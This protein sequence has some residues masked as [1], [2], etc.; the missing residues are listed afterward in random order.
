[1]DVIAPQH[2]LVVQVVLSGR[3]WEFDINQLQVSR[4]AWLQPA[5]PLQ[6]NGTRTTLGGQV[7]DQV[8]RHH[9][10]IQL[11]RLMDEKCP[12]HHLE[13][14]VDVAIRTQ[15]NGHAGRHQLRRW[16]NTASHFAIA[17]RHVSHSDVTLVNNSSLRFRKLYT[18]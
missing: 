12:A 16:C 1:M 7:P 4:P 8:S 11:V 13:E 5:H 9:L 6:A 15:A 10:G 18:L 14:V 2:Q 17:E 3:S